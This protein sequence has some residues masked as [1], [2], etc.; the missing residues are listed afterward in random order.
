MMNAWG[1]RKELITKND[2]ANPKSVFIVLDNTAVNRNNSGH[3]VRKYLFTFKTQE[4]ADRFYKYLTLGIDDNNNEE[5]NYEEDN[6]E[7]EEEVLNEEGVNVD[8]TVQ[9]EMVRKALEECNFFTNDSI[10]EDDTDKE[11]E[12]DKV[13]GEGK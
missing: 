2:T 1:P 3:F 8:K 5:D 11:D 10:D 6:Y 12:S 13:K 4:E 7:E 9:E